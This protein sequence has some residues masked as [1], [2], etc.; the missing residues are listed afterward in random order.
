ML[1]FRW[2][3]LMSFNINRVAVIPPRK[4]NYHDDERKEAL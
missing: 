2:K 4:G 3:L 1:D